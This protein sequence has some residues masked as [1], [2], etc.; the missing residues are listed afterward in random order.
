PLQVT[1]E[2]IP[3][4]RIQQKCEVALALSDIPLVENNKVMTE[5]S[6]LEAAN[7]RTNL[8]CVLIFPKDT[9]GQYEYW[10]ITINLLKRMV[11]ALV[12]ANDVVAVHLILALFAS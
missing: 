9:E 8:V 6:K 2:L 7:S 1:E 4:A 12:H 5:V 3:T 10:V 11:S